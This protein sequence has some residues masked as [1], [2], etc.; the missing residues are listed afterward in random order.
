MADEILKYL[1]EQLDKFAETQSKMVVGQ[2]YFDQDN[3]ILYRKKVRGAVS[4]TADGE[5]VYHNI[6]DTTRANHTLPSGFV[7]Q[8]ILQKVNY[9][10]ND[11]ITVDDSAE[12]VELVLK[13]WKKNL[14]R[15]AIT[16]SQQIY[17]VW[18]WYIKDSRLEYKR[19]DSQ[20][21]IVD[22]DEDDKDKIDTVIRTYTNDDDVEVAEIYTDEEKIVFEK[23]KSKKWTLVSRGSHFAE[24]T[25]DSNGNVLSENSIG[26]GRPPFSILFNNDDMQ[27]DIHPIKYHVD[28][29]DIT[30]SDFANNIDDFQEI[31]AILKGYGGENPAQFLNE[32]K[33]L[34]AVPVD[35]DGDVEFK[36]GIIPTAARESFLQVV[37]DDIYDNGM[38]V[39]VKKVAA[40]NSTNVA[41]Q[42]MYENLNMK[43]SQFEQELQDFWN[44]CLFFI[45]SYYGVGIENNLVFD[46]T[47]LSNQIDEANINKLE[48]ETIIILSSMLDN[49]TVGNILSNLHFIEDKSDMTQEEII[50]SV[51]SKSDEFIIPEE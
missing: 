45:N 40:G 6:T 23:K 9:L 4:E 36:Q 16:A 30:T 47:M 17:G 32:M 13:D 42:S 20:Q 34:G 14:K 5:K 24:Q 2:R 8:Q 31:I 43:A 26:W 10:I 46:K 11:N 1:E 35:E 15:T 27:T 18:Q 19:I 51:I 38:A 21:I 3:D 41:I 50:K 49:K 39:D 44:Q 33:K 25:V 12:D 37:R 22:F 28:V 48:A 29:Y 7:R